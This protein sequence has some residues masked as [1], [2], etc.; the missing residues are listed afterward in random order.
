M[1]PELKQINHVI[2][3]NT[4]GDVAKAL[5]GLILV[6][7]KEFAKKRKAELLEEIAELNN[8]YMLQGE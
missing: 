7:D 3:Y 6:P 4:P 2:R 8:H 5:Q 1:L